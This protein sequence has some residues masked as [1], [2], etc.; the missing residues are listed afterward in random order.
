M[1][2]EEEPQQEESTTIEEEEE[3]EVEIPKKKTTTSKTVKD[4]YS[5][6]NKILMKQTGIKEK[7]LEGMSP[8]ER[9]DR[10]SFFA[11]HSKTTKNQ[12]VIPENPAGIGAREP[13]G[14]SII[15]HPVTGR[16]TYSLD[17]TKLFKNEK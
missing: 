12:K 3:E 9:F 10:L 11:E 17:P 4:D 1:S 2:S 16:K 5:R 7:Q 15:E 8:K 14:I 6:M 13:T